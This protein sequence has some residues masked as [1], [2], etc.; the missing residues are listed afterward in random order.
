MKHF[1]LVGGFCG[2]VLALCGS[3]SAGN[4]VALALRDGAVGCLC[5]AVLLRGFHWAL[6]WSMQDF[7]MERNRRRRSDADKEPEGP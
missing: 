3:I 1:Q 2:F 6:W 4:E 7:A 5:G